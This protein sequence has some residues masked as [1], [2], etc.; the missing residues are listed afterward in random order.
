M[1]Y[2][3]YDT[4]HAGDVVKGVDGDSEWKVAQ[5]VAETAQ[6]REITLVRDGQYVTGYPEPGTP[7]EVVSRSDVSAEYAAAAALIASFG[8]IEVLG[9]RWN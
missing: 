3:T 1:E 7:V 5:V 4:L 6:G 8:S 2:A 9:E